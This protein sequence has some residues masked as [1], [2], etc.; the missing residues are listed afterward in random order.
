MTDPKSTPLEE[1][2]FLYLTHELRTPMNALLG[3]SQ[4]LRDGAYGELNPKQQ[5]RLDRVV[6][7]AQLVLRRLDLLLDFDRLHQGQLDLSRARVTLKEL[8]EMALAAADYDNRGRRLQVTLPEKLL[9]AVLAVNLSWGG[10]AV[11]EV[12]LHAASEAMP[13]PTVWLQAEPCMQGAYLALD[14]RYNAP[15]MDAWQRGNLFT[16]NNRTG[17]GLPLALQLLSRMGGSIDYESE[18]T[19]HVITL[20][21]PLAEA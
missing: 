13:D 7:S 6:R 3:F 2:V 10:V 12:I 19:R 4:M 8:L 1:W 11:R 17:I 20:T 18:A 15:P 21:L 5:D 16:L 9:D 14:V